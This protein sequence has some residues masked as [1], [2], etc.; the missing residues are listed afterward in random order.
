MVQM[1]RPR[2]TA[3]VAIVVPVHDD[4]TALEELLVRVAA[5]TVRPRELVVVASAA[6]DALARICGSHD[7]SMI[8]AAANRGA[9]LDAG[10]RASNAS[11]LW[12]VHADAAPPDD[13]L[14]AIE[15]AVAGG[16][17]SGCFRFSFQG[18]ACWRKR[19][20]AALVNWR[21]RLGGMPYGDQGLFASRTAYAACGGFAHQ[22]LFEE[23]DL[24][25][26]LRRRGTFRRLNRP[27][28]VSARRWESDGWWAR[29][30]RN[31]WLALCYMLGVPVERLAQAYGRRRDPGTRQL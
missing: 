27:L 11:I 20:L 4:A 29:T 10:A 22:P 31:R 25:K 18:P 6:D 14:A 2:M 8:A 13:A 30:F 15:Q 1:E 16:A 17:E 28:A 19:V 23:V 26:R 24:V 5:W 12:F 3:D 7:C 9:Q 21:T